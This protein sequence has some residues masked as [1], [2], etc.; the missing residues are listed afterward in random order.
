MSQNILTTC[1]KL[2]IRVWNIKSFFLFFSSNRTGEGRRIKMK[3][4]KGKEKKNRTAG[5]KVFYYPPIR[6]KIEGMGGGVGEEKGESSAGK[7]RKKKLL[8]CKRCTW[9]FWNMK[10][11]FFLLLLP[12]PRSSSKKKKKLKARRW[13]K[14]FK[15][16]F[17]NLCSLHA[18]FFF[19]QR[20]ENVFFIFFSFKFVADEK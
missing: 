17:R 9:A 7:K 11:S 14:K 8:I 15:K 3:R 2:S 20:R 19:S 16:L 13:E 1:G 10:K 12:V 5:K 18:K 6:G 4:G